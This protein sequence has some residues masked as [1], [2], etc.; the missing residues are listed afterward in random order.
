MSILVGAVI[1]LFLFEGAVE[2]SLEG[3][4]GVRAM[5]T[6]TRSPG[7]RD[8]I[9]LDTTGAQKCDASHCGSSDKSVCLRH[10]WMR[11]STRAN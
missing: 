4:R 11:G 6:T 3:S 10:E 2:G 1:A 9:L 7:Y 5:P 8:T